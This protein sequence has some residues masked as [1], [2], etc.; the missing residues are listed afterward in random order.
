MSSNI[1]TTFDRNTKEYWVIFTQGTHLIS[2]FLKDNFSH[3]YVITRD[4]YNWIVLNPMRLYMLVEI[5]AVPIT[6]DLP[7]LLR[8]PHDSIIKV[9]MYSRKPLKQFRY[10][11]LIN[12]VTHAL[13]LMGLRISVLTPFRLYKRLLRLSTKDMDRLGIQSIKQIT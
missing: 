8:L 1:E 11:G 7:R 3:V 9:T 10:F 12:C 6:D 2:H 5:A 4:K 13:Y